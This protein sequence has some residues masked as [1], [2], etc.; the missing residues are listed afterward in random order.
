MSEQ[1]WLS[2]KL[3]GGHNAITTFSKVMNM[4]APPARRIATIDLIQ[5]EGF[6]PTV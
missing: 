5:N 6:L 3:V 4:P 1:F 2:E